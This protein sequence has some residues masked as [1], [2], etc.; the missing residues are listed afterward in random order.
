LGE[1][2]SYPAQRTDGETYG[3]DAIHEGAIFR[4]PARL[5]LDEM[6][7]DPF[8][9]MIGKVFSG[10]PKMGVSS[11]RPVCPACAGLSRKR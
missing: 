3:A 5:N 10:D 8:A 1:R 6:Y 11:L 9:R 2:W 4:L 7:M